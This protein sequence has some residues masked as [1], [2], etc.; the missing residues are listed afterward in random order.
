MYCA[1]RSVIFSTPPP[2]E[3]MY[4]H[5]ILEQWWRKRTGEGNS[6]WN[7]GWRPKAGLAVS[8]G[9]SLLFFVMF[10]VAVVV[11]VLVVLF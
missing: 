8:T 4:F 6:W 2:V 9:S 3:I 7:T 5:V 11:V 10:I 1:G